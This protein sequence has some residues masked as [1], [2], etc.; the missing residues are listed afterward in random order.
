MD[1][2]R[3][4]NTDL[5][6]KQA[7]F[8]SNLAGQSRSVSFCSMMKVSIEFLKFYFPAEP[9]VRKELHNMPDESVFIYCLVGDRA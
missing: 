1:N 3:K 5:C 2:Q 6:V 9:V 8:V 7:M 4:Q